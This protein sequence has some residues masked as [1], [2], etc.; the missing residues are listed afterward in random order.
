MAIAIIELRPHQR[1]AV[2]AA[3]RALR[4]HARASVVAACGTGK[5][6]IAA[7]FAARGRSWYWYPPWTFC[8]RRSAPGTRLAAKA[9]R[10]QS[11]RPARPSSTRR[12][13]IFR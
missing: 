4:T 8:P 3:T 2:T 9:R 6:L 7:R 12:P 1:E 10:S 5:P 11:V 13:V